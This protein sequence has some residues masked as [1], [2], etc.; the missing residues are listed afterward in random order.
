MQGRLLVEIIQELEP[1]LKLPA[2]AAGQQSLLLNLL[3]AEFR[4]GD[5]NCSQPLLQFLGHLCQPRRSGGVFLE[6]TLDPSELLGQLLLPQLV[7]CARDDNARLSFCLQA[8]RILL[9]EG[10]LEGLGI[11]RAGARSTAFCCFVCGQLPELLLWLGEA[12]MVHLQQQLQDSVG[13]RIDE[14]RVSATA[15]SSAAADLVEDLGVEIASGLRAHK[16][17][18]DVREA[19]RKLLEAAS[20][21]PG[22]WTWNLPLL[23]LLLECLE[24]SGGL[25]NP[26]SLLGFLQAEEAEPPLKS[27][28]QVRG[29]TEWSLGGL[30][31]GSQTN[32]LYKRITMM[33]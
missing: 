25:Q 28:P 1:L 32:A 7:D 15:V 20:S 18:E 2:A 10:E 24:V 33:A 29:F 4:A 13:D 23:P 14:G 31:A 27:K 9:L 26:G 11:A 6:P 8:T 3:D 5:S 17:D 30:E 21:M 22:I 16:G 12:A 19:S